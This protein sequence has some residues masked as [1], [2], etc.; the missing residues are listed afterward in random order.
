MLISG[1]VLD[2]MVASGC[3]AEQIASVVKAACA[4]IDKANRACFVYRLVDPRNDYRAFYIGIANDPKRRL[5]DHIND[6]ASAAFKTLSEI[7]ATGYD[8]ADVMEIEIE[9]PT[10]GDARRVEQ[11]LINTTPGLVNR[12]G[13]SI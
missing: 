11:Q 3:T 13:G 10:R 1:D 6:P 9:C 8:L 4:S 2:A 7:E 5:K 12:A